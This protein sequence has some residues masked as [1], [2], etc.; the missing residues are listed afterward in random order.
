[1]SERTS[2]AEVSQ[3]VVAVRQLQ[4]QMAGLTE[5]LKLLTERLEAVEAFLARRD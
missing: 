1:V 5:A 4:Q 3:A 2:F